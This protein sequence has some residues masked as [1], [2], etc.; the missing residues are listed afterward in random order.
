ME[1]VVMTAFAVLLFGGV[2]ALCVLLLRDGNGP[3]GAH[4]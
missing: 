4:G 1:A 2:W 3:R